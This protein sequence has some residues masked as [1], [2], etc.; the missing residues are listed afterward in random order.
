MQSLSLYEAVEPKV[1]AEIKKE[2]C[3]CAVDEKFIEPIYFKD[4]VQNEEPTNQTE[5]EAERIV[6]VKE[7]I[8]IESEERLTNS[9]EF[10]D[11]EKVAV[12][13]EQI[14]QELSVKGDPDAECE[15]KGIVCKSFDKTRQNCQC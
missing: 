6:I 15:L 10:T 3:D 11:I 13:V 14:G 2:H 5:E 12:K 4:E 8:V 1:K 7:E 9:E